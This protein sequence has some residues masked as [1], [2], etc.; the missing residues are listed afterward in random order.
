MPLAHPIIL[1]FALP[2]NYIAHL[3]ELLQASVGASLSL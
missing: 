2:G 1:T 3:T